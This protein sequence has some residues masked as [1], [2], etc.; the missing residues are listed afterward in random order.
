MI[1]LHVDDKLVFDSRVE[2][3]ALLGLSAQLGLNK[4]GAATIILPPGHA[5]YEAFISYRSIVTIHRDG[6]LLF[7]GR[8]LYPTDDFQLQRTITCEGERCF[9]RDGIHRPYKYADTPGAIFQEV[10]GLY[11]AQ[12]ESDRKSVV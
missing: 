3:T 1:Q 12:V 11:N 6:V 10:I 5:A 8:A 2:S 4:G 7:R 9:L